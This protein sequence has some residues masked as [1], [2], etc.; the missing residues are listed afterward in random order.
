MAYTARIDS[1]FVSGEHSS[2]TDLA[3]QFVVHHP[4][5]VTIKECDLLD[6]HGTQSS[7]FYGWTACNGAIG[8]VLEIVL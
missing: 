8:S 3:I 6:F 7:N 1:I 2:D 5:G 4:D